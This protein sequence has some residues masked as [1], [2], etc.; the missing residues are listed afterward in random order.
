MYYSAFAVR[1][2]EVFV[3][4]C[5]WEADVFVRGAVPAE[6]QTI[7]LLWRYNN[8]TWSRKSKTLYY[9]IYILVSGLEF[10]CNKKL[11]N[12]L[13]AFKNTQKD[14]INII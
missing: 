11:L 4:I 1:T 3:Y 9:I 2:T 12:M 6:I 10:T 14:F 5:F 8:I 7:I 13:L